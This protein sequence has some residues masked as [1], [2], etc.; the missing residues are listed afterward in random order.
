MD[1]GRHAFGRLIIVSS[2]V[3]AL[4]SPRRLPMITV[5]PMADRKQL[6]I[7]ASVGMN[8]SQ[9]AVRGPAYPFLPYPTS[10]FR[11]CMQFFKPE[12][13]VS[14]SHAPPL[15]RWFPMEDQLNKDAA[16][17]SQFLHDTPGCSITNSH[18]FSDH[19]ISG[20]DSNT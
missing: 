11:L 1:L 7:R 16:Y 9:L 4:W 18:N 20:T 8:S 3:M 2:R 15:V 19:S 12:I 6:T 14:H 10:L 17:Y 5:G 13:V